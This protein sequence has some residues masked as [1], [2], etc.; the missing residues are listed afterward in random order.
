MRIVSEIK[1]LVRHWLLAL[2]LVSIVALGVSSCRSR[3]KTDTIED[4]S[5]QADAAP[6]DPTSPSSPVRIV[7]P[8]APGS[9][10]ALRDQLAASVVHLRS[11]TKVKGGP[12][13]L[14]PGNGDSLAL[15][16]AIVWDRTGHLLTNEHIIATAPKIEVLIGG[17]AYP[18]KVVGRDS[19]LDL[20]LLKTSAPVALLKPI[21]RGNSDTVSVG[22][23]VLALGNPLGTEVTASAGI[24]SSLGS[25]TQETIARKSTDYRSFLQTD[26]TIN[27]GNSGGP[28][29]DTSGAM[30]GINTATAANSTG[31]QVAI[32]I[33]RVKAIVSMLEKA[34]EVTRTWLGVFVHPV[35]KQVAKERKLKVISGALVSDLVPGS[36]AA[37]AGILRGDVILEFD[38]QTVNHR[39]LPAL[40]STSEVGKRIPILVWRSGAA[41]TLTLLSEKMP[42]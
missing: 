23:W 25:G 18:A 33:N 31:I 2:A 35:T 22:E 32:P 12:A 34:G 17:E 41:R 11:T 6:S 8:A 37:R 20:A 26:A 27:V 30:I 38:G 24:L 39:N 16:S 42:R 36:P 14:F 19:K 15:G 7:Y 10:V 21:R 9:F 28:L 5:I 40:S 4:A 3:S 13:S 1:A 29:I